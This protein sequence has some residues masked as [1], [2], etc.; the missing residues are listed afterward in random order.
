[1]GHDASTEW[2]IEREAKPV[3]LAYAPN[4]CGIVKRRMKLIKPDTELRA[5]NRLIRF[6]QQGRR[7]EA[8]NIDDE[9]TVEPHQRIRHRILQ[10]RMM[11]IIVRLQKPTPL[12]RAK[13]P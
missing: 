13:N 12:C 9:T 2:S 6:V 1:V 8:V 4:L 11:G 10:F 7:G 3:L 5:W